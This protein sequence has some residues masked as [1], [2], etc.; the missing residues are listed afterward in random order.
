MRLFT[1]SVLFVLAAGLSSPLGP[2]GFQTSDRRATIRSFE[3]SKKDF[4]VRGSNLAKVEIYYFATGTG[5]TEPSTL[6]L[7]RR[8]TPA[9]EN[10]TWVLPVPPKPTS[11]AGLL[12]VE[13]SA[14]GTDARGKGVGTKSLPF[15]GASSVNEGLWGTG[16]WYQIQ[17]KESGKQF[18]YHKGDSFDLFLLKSTYPLEELAASCSPARVLDLVPN[19][20]QLFGPQYTIRC[21]TLSVR[22]VAQLRTGIFGSP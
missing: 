15:Y 5:V 4:V 18:T 11:F 22:G 19:V 21:T 12:A 10:E 13:I 6:G 16:T 8:V 1:L 17:M 7:A 3:V 14:S 20:P 2:C 9:G